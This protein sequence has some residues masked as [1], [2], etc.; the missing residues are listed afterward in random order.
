M[1]ASPLPRSRPAFGSV[2]AAAVK[3]EL[4]RVQESTKPRSRGA[5][6][7]GRSPLTADS[8]PWYLGALG[9]LDVARRL[10]HLG[11]EWVVLHSVPVGTRGSDIDHVLIGPAGVFTLN[12]KHHAGGRVW[13]GSQRL[14]VN[15]QK[16]DYLR[17]ARHEA[18][19][20]ER[21]LR[22]ALG[23]EIKVR[24]VV[25][26]V[27]ASSVTY[28]NRPAGVSVVTAPQLLRWLRKQKTILEPAEV[29]RIAETASRDATWSA[30]PGPIAEESAF[31]A[32]QRDVEAARRVRITWG[33]AVGVGS[34]SLVASLAFDSISRL[35]IG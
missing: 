17:N 26:I 13:V 29:S 35:F 19:R 23:E 9:E 12:A 2:P 6:L 20:A 32:L 28:R 14:M 1:T 24:A 11:P 25:V 18:S 4:L 30:E 34:V 16:T 33:A 5:R 3:A 10:A 8:R 21:L 7:F 27:G 15:G 22:T 31:A